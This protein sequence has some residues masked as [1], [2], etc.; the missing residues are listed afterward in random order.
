MSTSVAEQERPEREAARK[1][2]DVVVRFAG[3]S[4]DGMQ[5]TGNQF[6]NTSA[7]LGNDLSTLPDFPAEIRAPAGTLPGVSSFQVRIADYDIHTP[8]DAPDV[9]VAMNPAALKK[10]IGDLKP[11][12]VV[13]VNS[14]EFNDRSFL[15]AGV[16]G[17]PLEDGSLDKFRVFKVDLTTMTRRTLEG[18]GLDTKS[19]DRCKNFF[20]LGMVYYLFTRPLDNTISWLQK[21]FAK[22]PLLA[23]ANVKVLKAG[24]NFCDITGLF[25]VRYEVAPAALEPGTYRNIHGNSALAMGLVAASRRSGLPLFLGAY[26][27]TPA[28]DVLHELAGYKQFGVTTLQ[29][30]DEIAAVCA[31]IGASFGGALAVTVSSG[32]GIALKAE[33]MN[34]AIMTELPLIVCDIQR[35]GPSTGL[36]TKTEQADLLQV[37]FG[38]NGESPLPIVAPSS[39]K[40]CFEVAL[41]AARI[42]LRHMTPVVLLSDGYIANGSEPWKLP[43]LAT[44][45]DLEVEFRRDPEGFQPYLRDPETL[46]RPWAIPGT[47]GLEHRIGGLEKEDVTGN[48]SYDPANHER[49]IHL[50]AEKVARVARDIPPL[51]VHGEPEGELLVL[52]WG[53]TAGAITGAVNSARRE[54]LAVSRAHLRHLNPFPSNLDEVLARFRR[55]LVPEMNLGQLALLLRA[56]TLK[57]IESFTKV[58]G[59]PFTRQEIY[60]RVRELLGARTMVH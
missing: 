50:R 22:K 10:E 8:G 12:G 56:R 31:A 37:M 27:I 49:M 40:D 19:M 28:S 48:V 35:G 23:E 9:L 18:S 41:E 5:L 60:D 20:A 30:E 51:E 15:R 6:S 58:Q 46:A 57:D 25:Q 4:G 3:D 44:L 16:T 14:D 24:W 54:G 33:A 11:N 39:P 47:P 52:G 36:P 26:P 59:K 29:A 53:S 1:L 42:A 13:I 2:D 38:R 7:L 45:P 34:L 43:D 55:V 21:N 17:N 32:P